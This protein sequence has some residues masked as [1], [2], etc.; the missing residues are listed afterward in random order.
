MTHVPSWGDG[1]PGAAGFATPRVPLGRDDQGRQAFDR[2]GLQIPL[3]LQNPTVP[4]ASIGHAFALSHG[5][6]Q[7]WIAS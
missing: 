1:T 3:L 2:L 7:I 6:V 4:A 5:W